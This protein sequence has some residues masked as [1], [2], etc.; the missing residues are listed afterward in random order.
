[1]ARTQWRASES[2]ASITVD[3]RNPSSP[4]A[5]QVF[6][7]EFSNTKIATA[8]EMRTQTR[9]NAVDKGPPWSA[10][11]DLLKH[12]IVCLRRRHNEIVKP[13][14]EHVLDRL[15]LQFRVTF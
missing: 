7:R 15:N 10:F 14:G 9:H 12:A 1:M 2:Y 8:D 3:R 5:D 13:M 6:R 4:L 11:L